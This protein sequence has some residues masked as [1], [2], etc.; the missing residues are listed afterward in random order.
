MQWSVSDF[1]MKRRLRW[2]GHFGLTSDD[3]LLLFGEL[4]MTRPFHGTKKQWHDGVLS[5]LKAI[6]IWYCLCQDKL[7]WTKLCNSKGWEVATFQATK[8]LCC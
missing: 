5:D 8:Y 2:V 6:S 7:Q 4:E 3:R 1:I